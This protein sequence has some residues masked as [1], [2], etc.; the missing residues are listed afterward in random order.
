MVLLL[1]PK[2]ALANVELF[3]PVWPRAEL[4]RPEPADRRVPMCGPMCEPMC[5]P[6]SPLLFI[7]ICEP[8]VLETAPPREI[9]E[10]RA[11]LFL[12]DVDRDGEAALIPRDAAGVP[13]RAALA[14]LSCAEASVPASAWPAALLAAVRECRWPSAAA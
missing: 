4:L 12:R 6:L 8:C 2:W 11:L 3:T 10:R 13:A 7:C 1:L 9:D 14:G 5:E